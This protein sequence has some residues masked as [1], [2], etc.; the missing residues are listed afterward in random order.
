[1]ELRE[2]AA[3]REVARQ[4]SFSRAAAR[5]GYVQSTVSAQIQA[6]EQDLGVR[7]IDRLGRSIALT[8]AGEALL[9]RAE[10]LLELASEAR[11]AATEA[12]RAGNTL[13]G[14]IAISAPETL[15]T[16]RLPA[17]LT[18]FRSRHPAVVIDLRPTPIGRFGAIPAVRSPTARSM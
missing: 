3:F 18:E 2:L 8:A 1:M 11:S 15:L 10:R 17:L 4:S 14:T 6:L 7:L 12:V 5:L 9:P 13:T 16:Y